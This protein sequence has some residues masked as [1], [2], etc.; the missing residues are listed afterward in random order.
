MLNVIREGK[1]AIMLMSSFKK[2]AA[3]FIVVSAW[4]MDAG[5][6]DVQPQPETVFD[7]PANTPGL[8]VADPLQPPAMDNQIFHVDGFGNGV[9]VIVPDTNPAA[10]IYF[11][12]DGRQ[13]TTEEAVVWSCANVDN[14]EHSP[15]TEWYMK[16]FGVIPIG[17]AEGDQEIFVQAGWTDDP[18]HTAVKIIDMDGMDNDQRAAFISDFRKIASN[19]VGRELLYRILIEIRRYKDK[20]GVRVG[21]I[22]ADVLKDTWQDLLIARNEC[23]STMI[24]WSNKGNYFNL[25]GRTI[26]F[27]SM[28]IMTTTV[29]A[30]VGDNHPIRL[31][32]RES[33]IGLFHEMIHWFHWL[34]QPE[35]FNQES[36]GYP[37]VFEEGLERLINLHETNINETLGGYFWGNLDGANSQDRWKVSAIPWLHESRNHKIFWVNFEEIRAILGAPTEEQY[38]AKVIKNEYHEDHYYYLNGDDLSENKYRVSLKKKIRFGHGDQAFYEDKNVIELVKAVSGADNENL[39]DQN[40]DQ[41]NENNSREGLGNFLINVYNEDGF[42]AVMKSIVP[43]IL[44]I[45]ARF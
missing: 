38:R 3:I 36:A 12:V 27:R 2:I 33:S 16:V 20:D 28:N 42:N 24:K 34:R 21:V 30:L 15:I 5:A 25:G 23:R 45:P 35:R 40:L 22:G 6:A 19:L 26:G 32:E 41:K 7:L 18:N 10:H 1:R 8:F 29:S 17:Q 44:I 39:I 43:C 37:I 4:A 31:L 9:H 13:P 14:R 11:P